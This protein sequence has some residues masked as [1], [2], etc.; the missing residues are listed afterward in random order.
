MV[1]VGNMQ[2]YTQLL[3]KFDEN[4]EQAYRIGSAGYRHQQAALACH[5]LIFMN[6]IQYFLL[7]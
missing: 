6:K 3:P 4:I 7:K 2:L 5:Q 1:E